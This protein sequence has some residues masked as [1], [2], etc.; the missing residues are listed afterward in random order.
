[1]GRFEEEHSGVCSKCPNSL[2]VKVGHQK[3]CVLLQEI[4]IPNWKWEDIN[5]D[6][7]VGLPQ[8]DNI[9]LYG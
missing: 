9:I 7:V 3:M 5:M 1:M 2:Q 8:T 4:E 6:F